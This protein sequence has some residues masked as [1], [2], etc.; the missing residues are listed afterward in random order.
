MREF[1][2]NDLH[3]IEAIKQHI[4]SVF[5]TFRN[6]AIRVEDY[7]VVLL[8]LTYYREG[9]LDEFILGDGFDGQEFDDLIYNLLQSKNSLNKFIEIHKELGSIL[10]DVGNSSLRAVF[11]IIKLINKDVL[12]KHFS[13][14]FDEVLFMIIESKGARGSEQVQPWELSRF[15]IGISNEKATDNIFNPFAGLASYAVMLENGST[16]YGQEINRKTWAI[17]SLRIIASRRSGESHYFC[18]NS[19]NNWPQRDF[20]LIISTPPFRVRIPNDDLDLPTFI[21]TSEQFLLYKGLNSLNINGKMIVIV[22][23][24]FLS[25]GAGDQKTRELLVDSGYLESVISLPAGIF[26]GTGIKTCIL[27]INEAHSPQDKVRFINA[28]TFYRSSTKKKV[29][30]DYKLSGIYADIIENEFSWF[31]D[32]DKIREND[33]NLIGDR[34]RFE[35]IEG[36]RLGEII[37]PY[38]GFEAQIEEQG[39]IVKIRDLSNDSIDAVLNLSFLREELILKPRFKRIEESCLLI[40]TRWKSLKP[41]YFQ[42]E[43]TPIYIS[44]DIEAFIIDNSKAKTSYLINELNA[45]YVQKQLKGY[46]T[47]MSVPSIGKSDL[48]KIIVKLPSIDKQAGKAEAL[49]ELAEKMKFIINERD[50]LVHDNALS[51]YDEFASLKHTLGTPRQNILDWADNLLD[52]FL[53]KDNNI[54]SISHEFKSFYGLDIPEA[55]KEIKKDI[56]HMTEILERGEKGLILEDYP[57]SLV[58]LKYLNQFIIEISNNG[59]NYSLEKEILPNLELS[60]RGI[61]CNMTLLKVLLDN[62][63]NNANKHGFD[64]KLQSNQVV[65]ELIDQGENLLLRI[66]NN[67]KPFP[68]NFSKEKFT[69]KFST[70]N[71]NNGTGLGGYDIN[72]IAAYFGNPDWELLID[73]KEIYPVEFEFKFKIKLIG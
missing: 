73:D 32:N 41:T 55:L 18:N 21:K 35:S 23:Q 57:L 45:D 1:T 52:F 50:E 16:Y 48:L 29:L 31:V 12:N 70:A 24:G 33:F 22:S 3:P 54:K 72:R 28:E 63:L 20:D 2:L 9:I 38:T 59:F 8:I 62:I 69:A 58:S 10:G 27:V 7:D 66:R 36:V 40:A 67:G 60:E 14:I 64:Q 47:A 19:I 15:I 65:I 5:N 61:D 34:Y 37:K 51:R 17:G 39:L 26:Q 56:G 42:F 30:N 4:L 44:N 46:S 6:E 49:I 13:E 71:P 68:K 11:N 25:N 43:G 53:K